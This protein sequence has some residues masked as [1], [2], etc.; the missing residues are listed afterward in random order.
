MASKRRAITSFGLFD[1]YGFE[2]CQISLLEV[3]NVESKD[4]L[5]VRERHY[6]ESC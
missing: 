5:K 3:A 4:A 1:K 2:N 6:I